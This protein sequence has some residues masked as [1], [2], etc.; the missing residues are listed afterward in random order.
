LKIDIEGSEH[1]VLHGANQ[2]IAGGIMIHFEFN[3]MNIVGRTLLKYSNYLMDIY[4]FYRMLSE[5]LIDLGKCRAY[6]MEIF[7]YQSIV[8]IRH[9]SRFMGRI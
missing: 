7:G 2:A 3:E 4:R 6:R 9:S 1:K 5:G 8:A